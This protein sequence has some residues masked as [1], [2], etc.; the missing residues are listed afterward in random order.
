MIPKG[1]KIGD[2][3]SDGALYEVIGFDSEGRYISRWAAKVA[4]TKITPPVVKTEEKWL[5]KLQSVM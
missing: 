1:L 5:K 4:P 3:F 2:T